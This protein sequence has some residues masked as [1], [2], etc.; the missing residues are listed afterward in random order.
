MQRRLEKE[1]LQQG[2][3]TNIQIQPVATKMQLT[4]EEE[5]E[6]DQEIARYYS[7]CVGVEVDIY[8]NNTNRCIWC[9]NP[10]GVPY[11][12][13]EYHCRFVTKEHPTA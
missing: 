9:N 6:L 8:D 10:M 3:S 4:K 12:I 7:W 11:K 13:I 5:D 1:R 2:T